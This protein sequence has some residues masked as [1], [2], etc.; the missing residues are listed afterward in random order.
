VKAKSLTA[1]PANEYRI[2]LLT[3]IVLFSL[4]SSLAFAKDPDCSGVDR[5]PTSMAFVR[6]KNAGITDN[7]RIDFSKTRTIRLA[8]EKIGK[9]LYRQI[10]HVKF[11]EKTGNAIEVI[12]SNEVSDEECSMSEVDVFVIMQHLEKLVP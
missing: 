4:F 1:L 12:T 2:G 6:L 5:W 7:E 8:S 9:G 10:H 3:V 11:I